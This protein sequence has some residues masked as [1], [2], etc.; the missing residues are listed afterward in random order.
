VEILGKPS[1]GW[2]LK[3]AELIRGDNQKD[4]CRTF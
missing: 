1:L 2:W 4:L 3:T